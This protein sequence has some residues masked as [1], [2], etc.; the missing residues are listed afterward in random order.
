MEMR[1]ILAFGAHP[2][3]IE[4]GCGG[5]LLKYVNSG[6]KVYMC[7]LSRGECAG[8]PAVRTQEQEE[9]ARRLGAEEL[10]WGDWQDT[11]F[12][13]GQDSVK[14]IENVVD[15][16][17]PYEIYVN[18]KEDTHQDHRVL[19]QCVLSATRYNKRVLFYE[20]Y[21]SIEFQPNIFVDIEDVFDDKVAVLSAFNSQVSR[22]FPSGPKM[23]DGVRAV[24][25]FRGFQARIR[26]AE[27][28]KA[29]RYLKLDFENRQDL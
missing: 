20:D 12:Q 19:A 18:Y 9:A 17:K 16:V 5:T 23:I 22:K 6:F 4:L 7:V 11:Q 25:N 2:D 26:Y 29:V 24:A 13:V 8:D 3:D 10:I 27:A 1:N 14:F 21:T 15:L 28:F